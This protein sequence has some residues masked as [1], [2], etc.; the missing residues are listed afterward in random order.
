MRVKLVLFTLALFLLSSCASNEQ[1]KSVTYTIEDS[2]KVFEIEEASS[3]DWLKA[4]EEKRTELN[5]IRAL[6]EDE[7]NLEE[8]ERENQY[9]NIRR[10][11]DGELIIGYD[12]D[13]DK[14]DFKE[15]E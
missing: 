14:P 8:F 13:L 10:V 3:L 11:I 1:G 6:R 5:E 2:Q 9:K 12:D 15:V 4:T 7:D